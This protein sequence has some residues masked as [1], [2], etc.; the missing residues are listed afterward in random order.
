MKFLGVT[1]ASLG[2]ASAA[3]VTKKV[4]YDDWKVYRVNV[5]SNTAKF[6]DVVSKLQLETWKGKPASSDVVDVMVPPSQISDFVTSTEGIETRIMHENLGVSIADEES[7]GVYAAGVAPDATWFNS[8][9][10]IADH[11]QW[12]TDLVAAYPS[13]AEVFSA[14]KS[15]EGRDIKG[16]HIWGSGGKGSQKGVVWH[17]TVH[18]REWITTMVVEYAAYQLLT[19]SASAALKNKFD[20]YIIPIVNPDGFAF[21]QTSDRL[22]RK[23]RQT[24][25]TASCVGRDINRNWPSHWDQRGGASTS[26]CAQD[27]KGPSAGDGVETKALKAHLDSVAAGKGV[28]LYMDIHSYSQLWM[29]P[30]GWTCSGVLPNAAKYQSLTQGAIA[31]VKAVHGTQFTG[32]PIC[33]TI[34]QVSGDSVDYAFEVAKA[35]YSMTVELRDTGD[36]GFVLPANQIVPSGEETWAG[37]SYLLK[38]I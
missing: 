9:H 3:S 19:N 25:P 23:N 24:T 15:V 20:Y 36:F 14:G 4:S 38:N 5:G 11:H 34:Y 35:N 32:G 16:I 12:I 29:Y 2:L 18:A 22:W 30:Y 37:L 31:A 10:S 33:N 21:S 8:Y 7:F 13:N 1:L 6:N 26:P 27:Y 28:Q 17:G